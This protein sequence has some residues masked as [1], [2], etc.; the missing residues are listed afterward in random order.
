V[1][2]LVA[3]LVLPAV[4]CCVEG[5]VDQDSS[6]VDG[7]RDARADEEG[8]GDLGGG[9]DGGDA[10]EPT[11]DG[12][13]SDDASADAGMRPAPSRPPAE[14]PGQPGPAPTPKTEVPDELVGVWQSSPI[15]FELWES[16]REGYYAGRNA[17]PSR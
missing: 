9:H 12:G 5:G 13:G 14:P 7:D 16:Y 17:V 2:G 1:V 15:D 4:S 8:P 10:G 3:T 11:R 6:G